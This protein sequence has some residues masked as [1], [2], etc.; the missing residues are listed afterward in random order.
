MCLQMFN[1]SNFTNTYSDKVTVL[2]SPRSM[3]GT[4]AQYIYNIGEYR[5][6]VLAFRRVHRPHCCLQ[7]LYHQ[8]YLHDRHHISGKMSLWNISTHQTTP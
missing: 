6:V 8:N 3:T 2:I 4:L 1:P 7:W 5:F